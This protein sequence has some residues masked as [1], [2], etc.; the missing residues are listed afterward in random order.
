MPRKRAAAEQIIHRLREV[1]VELAFDNA[2]GPQ[3]WLKLIVRLN[4]APG[5]K[6]PG[7]PC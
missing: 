5:F 7:F 6:A 3:E 4:Q 2:N 1:A